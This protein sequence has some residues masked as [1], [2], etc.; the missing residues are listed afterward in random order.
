MPTVLRQR[1]YRFHFY[2]GDR[3]EPAHV[4]V[5]RGDSDGKVWLTPTIAAAYLHGFKAQERKEIMQIINENI[6][7]LK[8]KWNEFFQE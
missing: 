4:H 2:A 5:E 8:E 6:E 1:G 3:E 7:L